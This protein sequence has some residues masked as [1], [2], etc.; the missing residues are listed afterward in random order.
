[1]GRTLSIELGIMCNNNCLF[2]YQRNLRRVKAYP[3]KLPLEEVKR[4]LRWG[5]ENG[6]VHVGFEGGEP[7]VRDDLVDIIAFAKTLG[8]QRI[9]IT[10]NGRRLSR[11]DLARALVAAGLNGVGFSIHGPDATTHQ[12]HTLRRRSF[13]QAMAGVK[14][15]LAL[16]G[17]TRIDFNIFTVVTRRNKDKLVDIGRM[18]AAMGIHLLILQPLT[19]SKGNFEDLRDLVLPMDQ[20]VNGI[21]TAIYGGMKHGYHVKLFNLPPCLFS[22]ILPGLEMDPLPPSVFREDEKNRAGELL[23]TGEDGYVRLSSCK[24]CAINRICPGLPLSLLPQFDLLQV[25]RRAVDYHRGPLAELWLTGM[26]LAGPST[27]F[28]LARY[29]ISSG[30]RSV[31]LL[32]GGTMVNPLSYRA[33][34]RAGM[35]EIIL[36]HRPRDP[37]SEDRLLRWSGNG[38]FLEQTLRH[39]AGV[40]GSRRISLFSPPGKALDALLDRLETAGLD[41][42]IHAVRVPLSGPGIHL[43]SRVGMQYLGRLLK[44]TSGRIIIELNNRELSGFYPCLLFISLISLGR[45]E[46]HL[47]GSQVLRTP[48]SLPGYGLLNWSDPLPMELPEASGT[49]TVTSLRSQPLSLQRLKEAMVLRKMHESGQLNLVE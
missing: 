21:R 9:G 17:H 34:L 49:I 48:F 29:A 24:Y 12:A 20:V 18:F 32:T 8:Y 19:Y 4:K 22:D 35:D 45:T 6:F 16:A 36:V 1:M 47:P 3:K 42:Y 44:R 41:Q 38:I 26:E 31:K 23:A 37:R 2:C 15:M 7:T 39:L 33:A 25:L 13:E 28:D 5:R 43:C 46:F 40:P 14:N 27:T 30:Y 11:P 10:T